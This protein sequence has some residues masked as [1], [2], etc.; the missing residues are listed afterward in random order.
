MKPALVFIGFMGAGKSTALAAAREAGL[1][2]TEIDELMEARARQA[3][4]ARPSS[5]TARRPSAP[6]RPRWS[7]RCSTRPT[8]ARSRSAA[9]AC[10]PSA[11]ARR[12][13][14][15]VVVWLQV[16]ATRGLAR[17]SPAAIARW[18]PAPRTSPQL[19][20]GAP[21]ALRGARRRDR[22]AGRPR[23]GRPRDALAAGAGRAAARDEDAL[24]GE[25]LGRVPGLRRRRVCSALSCGRCRGGA[26]ASPTRA[27]GALYARATRAAWTPASRSSRAS[28]RRRWP[29]PSGCCAS[30][31]APG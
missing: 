5:G 11:C 15:H 22:P 20:R 8:A 25:R 16:D 12:L 7:A 4:R 19:H 21:A 1:E 2:T 10:S 23:P 28:R 17:G 31:P 24:G 3:D 27:V 18:R 14:R 9:A 30:W 29:R 26:S 6:A 13:D